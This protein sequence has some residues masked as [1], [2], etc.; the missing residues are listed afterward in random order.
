MTRK[1]ALAGACL[2]LLGGCSWF[3]WLP[4]V[5]GD[6][7]KKKDDDLKPAKL[8][9]YDPKDIRKDEGLRKQ[10]AEDAAEIVTHMDGVASA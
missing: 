8:T 9:K 5:E 2:F 1:L 3:S 10:L 6:G 4:W 7:G